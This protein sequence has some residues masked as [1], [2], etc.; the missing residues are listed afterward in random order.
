ML[1]NKK[2]RL[3]PTN[4]PMLDAGRHNVFHIRPQESVPAAAIEHA[5]D[6]YRDLMMVARGNPALLHQRPF[7]TVAAFAH[8]RFRQLFGGLS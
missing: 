1:D 8:C 6:E 3:A 7:Q 5:W 2:G 4:R